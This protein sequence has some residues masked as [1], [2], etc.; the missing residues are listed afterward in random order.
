MC[1]LTAKGHDTLSFAFTCMCLYTRKRIFW[2]IRW[3]R[4][5]S[6]ALIY[7]VCICQINGKLWDLRGKCV[8]HALRDNFK[9]CST[10]WWYI[11]PIFLDLKKIELWNRNFAQGLL[12]V[13]GTFW[14]LCH[15]LVLKAHWFFASPEI[16][17]FGFT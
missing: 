10:Q 2:V 8:G 11:W 9:G 17:K 1:I 5:S 15:A 3:F 4:I 14:K 6:R 12:L 16:V 13:D 7:E